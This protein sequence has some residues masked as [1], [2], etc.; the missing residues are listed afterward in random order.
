MDCIPTDEILDKLAPQIGH[1]F[2]QLGVAL[3][4]SIPTLENI[5]S[6]NSRDLA[7]QN[8]EVLFTWR[9]DKTVKPSLMVLMQ[10]LSDIRRGGLCLEEI[11]KNMEINTLI[12]SQ[13]VRDKP[14]KGSIPKKKTEKIGQKG[15]HKMH[16]QLP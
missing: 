1:V 8:R 12:A 14:D 3:G 13:A 6:N 15:K 11:M 2:F 16:V 7:A 9:K 5:Q 10:A 4:L